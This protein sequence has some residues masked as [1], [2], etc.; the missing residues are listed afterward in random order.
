[1]KEL[2][3]LSELRTLD[4]SFCAITDDGLK[5]L[6]GIKTLKKVIVTD[7]DKVTETGVTALKVALPMCEVIIVKFRDP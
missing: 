4:L 1:L 7:D 3:H 5:E 2:K 6:Y